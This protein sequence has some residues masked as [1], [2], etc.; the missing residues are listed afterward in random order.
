MATE[1]SYQKTY[2]VDKVDSSPSIGIKKVLFRG[3]SV[4]VLDMTE[5]ALRDLA[6]KRYIGVV[7]EF[8]PAPSSP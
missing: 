3:N 1:V 5:E 6:G 2:R 8:Y 4:K 7:S